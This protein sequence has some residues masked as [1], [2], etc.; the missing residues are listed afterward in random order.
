MSSHLFRRIRRAS[1]VPAVA[2]IVGA[3]EPNLT[4]VLHENLLTRA[5]AVH[6]R[7]DNIRGFVFSEGNVWLKPYSA[8]TYRQWYADGTE[9]KIVIETYKL[10]IEAVV[11][12]RIRPDLYAS[13]SL[14][15][16]FVPNPLFYLACVPYSNGAYPNASAFLKNYQNF[17][18]S[19]SDVEKAESARIGDKGMKLTMKHGTYR[20]HIIRG[21]VVFELEF[22]VRGP[23]KE[24]IANHSTM[25]PDDQA[26][27]L[28]EIEGA[29][30]MAEA[31]LQAEAEFTTN[32]FSTWYDR[33]LA[34]EANTQTL[35]GPGIKGHFPWIESGGKGVALYSGLLTAADAP[36]EMPVFDREFAEGTRG[37]TQALG[38]AVVEFRRKPVLTKTD[39][40]NNLE[41]YR[42]SVSTSIDLGSNADLKADWN[43]PIKSVELA[44]KSFQ[45]RLSAMD[46]GVKF[47]NGYFQRSGSGE[48]NI[49]EVRGLDKDS[50]RDK[51]AI[52]LAGADEAYKGL[53][54]WHDTPTFSVVA[55]KGNLIVEVSGRD[56]LNNAMVECE[57]LAGLFV[58]RLA[59]LKRP[60][61][62]TEVD[63]GEL[64]FYQVALTATPDC[65]WPDETSNLRLEVRDES[66]KPA[67]NV[68]FPLLADGKPVTELRTDSTGSATYAF[69]AAGI[70]ANTVTAE[71]RS[72]KASTVIF[73]GGMEISTTPSSGNAF[74][75]GKTPLG[76]RVA[77]RDPRGKAIA[78]VKI[79][80][81]EPSGERGIHGQLSTAGEGE[82]VTGTV[83]GKTDRDG[84]LRFEYLAPRLDAQEVKWERASLRFDAEAG[85]GVPKL[86]ER[87]DFYIVA[88]ADLNIVV[89][90][91]GFAANPVPLRIR[92]KNGQVRGH[93]VSD[94]G[95]F[96]IA[97]AE[98]VVASLDGKPFG[99]ATA[100][101]KGA[102]DVTF[103]TDPLSASNAI[104]DVAEPIAVPLA[105]DLLDRQQHAQ[106]HLDRLR[107]H[108]YDV[109]AHD[110]FWKE[111]PKN[112][113]AAP[114]AG[115]SLLKK[116]LTADY[117]YYSATRLAFMA[118]FASELNER[119]VESRAW[120]ME[121]FKQGIEALGTAT[122]MN[123]KLKEKAKD[124]LGEGCKTELWQNWS[125]TA[126]KKFVDGLMAQI[127]KAL[128]Q[129]PDEIK[130]LPEIKT[131]AENAQ[132][133]LDWYEDPGEQAVD[134]GSAWLVAKL[135]ESV[136]KAVVGPWKTY[137]QKL[138]TESVARAVAGDL[139]N[140]DWAPAEAQCRELFVSFE[141]QHYDLNIATCDQE[142][143]RLWFGLAKDT[144]GK[145]VAI[146][147]GTVKSVVKNL[148]TTTLK[149]LWSEMSVE[150][151]KD[152]VGGD[153]KE[154]F[155]GLQDSMKKNTD[156]VDRVASVF[157]SGYQA[158]RGYNWL[159]DAYR[160]HYTLE[161]IRRSLVP[162]PGE[163]L[164]AAP[165]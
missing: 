85:Q 113:A 120:F 105:P 63:E 49:V 83:S 10:E 78:S 2:L 136:E 76:F 53:V 165:P 90:K 159:S 32:A 135:T 12:G 101:A 54:C 14:T 122:E 5:A 62:P 156:M 37:A 139:P 20:Y 127:K 59:T 88:G 81:T 111:L 104:E 98:V 118:L 29:H 161:L 112:L 35:T 44:K 97:G 11:E 89:N 117:W 163:A 146:Y 158:Y 132:T 134:K 68:T 164:R 39:D 108:G 82:R 28:A 25:M 142:L 148:N 3:A 143:Y 70:Y 114:V 30:R 123:D 77:L 43:T 8:G 47:F 125:Q 147:F 24:M 116:G 95:A 94:P 38:G 65:V 13:Q 96:P 141:K 103:V 109:A 41:A 150:K 67:A 6:N 154:F 51:V 46:Y 66:G 58:R 17:S 75:D 86:S 91:P 157:D 18:M 145:G 16:R 1:L 121:S 100:D 144:V 84:V 9:K 160:T 7:G 133:A 31:D 60:P 45:S 129:L 56:S 4:R 33:P 138:L 106:P 23:S 80:M 61:P 19:P 130:S 162:S 153:P 22:G 140:Q 74:G 137:L 107:S 50:T 40:A 99:R 126:L 131:Y 115:R 87:R 52:S 55:R 93:L 57:R 69:K 102:F 155:E 71:S 119:H 26:N 79:T 48:K 128:E 110:R 42:V 124:V 15:G 151:I 36:P 152:I 21:P 72:G 149:S 73:K 27:L 64:R 92:A 34:G